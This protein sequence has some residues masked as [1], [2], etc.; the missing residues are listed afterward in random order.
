VTLAAKIASSLSLTKQYVEL[1]GL[2][3]SYRYKTYE[4]PKKRGGTRTINHPARELKLF[5]RW[6]IKNLLSKLPIHKS[7]SAYKKGGSTSRNAARHRAKNFLLKV[8]F[9]DFFPSI[10]GRDIVRLLN[11]N[12]AMLVG[13]IETN[14][15]VELV[16]RFVC[17]HDRLTIGAPSSPILSNQ[18]MY[19][20]DERWSSRCDEKRVTYS[21][22]ADDLYFST[23]SPNVLEGVLAELRRDLKQRRTPELQIN[24]EKTVFTSRKRR[25]LITGLVRKRFIKSLVFRNTTHQLQPTET[26]YLRG[27]LAYAQ[28]VEPSFI[29]ALLRKYGPGALVGL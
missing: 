4:I 21:R 17:R 9:R 27:I 11:R 20:F 23:T 13:L 12:R 24:E 25:R 19:E 7:A 2:T 29:Q 5:Q 14:A 1:V 26:E 8:D 6:L 10:R 16:R 18:V 3:A 15:D 22:Y 28:S